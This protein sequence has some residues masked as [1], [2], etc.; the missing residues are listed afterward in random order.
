MTST[1][2]DP[3]TDAWGVIH[4]PWIGRNLVLFP[5]LTM[6]LVDIGGGALLAGMAF[7][8]R[9]TSP[10]VIVMVALAGLAVGGVVFAMYW[11]I[12]RR[13]G[14]KDAASGGGTAPLRAE[15]LLA[16]GIIQ[17]PAVIRFADGRLRV[18]PLVGE[19]LELDRG[20]ISEVR[21]RRFYNGTYYFGDNAAF[22]LTV[23]GHDRRVGIIVPRPARWREALGVAG[24]P[25]R[26]AG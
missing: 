11:T 25:S 10:L 4:F 1:N 7:S 12:A 14:A 6:V 22:A 15:G 9:A 19:P 26:P 8:G 21:E 24:G 2:T 23:P 17:G 18:T 20:R 13:L 3:P 16:H 5:L